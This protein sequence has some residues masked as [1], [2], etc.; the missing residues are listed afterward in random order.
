MK[1]L[2]RAL[3][4]ALIIGLFAVNAYAQS[5]STNVST[6]YGSV[7]INRSSDNPGQSGNNRQ[8]VNPS[9]Y[10]D[11]AEREE[12][13]ENRRRYQHAREEWEAATRRII[14]QRERQ[15]AA[16]HTVQPAAPV[17]GQRPQ[18]APVRQA[19]YVQRTVTATPATTTAS[20]SYRH[21]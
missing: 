11:R 20:G 9:S 21:R 3:L 7:N 4:S 13:R 19:Q 10:G 14:E 15:A 16:V 6:P 1:T 12:F 18:T 2:V 17:N 8:W 5:V